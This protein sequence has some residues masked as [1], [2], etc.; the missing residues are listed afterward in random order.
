MK[1]LH[2]SSDSNIT[3]TDPVVDENRSTI[4]I[5]NIIMP[6]FYSSPEHQ[7]SSSN[8]STDALINEG[9]ERI[10]HSLQQ[11]IQEAQASLTK[12]PSQQQKRP[13]PQPHPLA[14][15]ADMKAPESIST[16]HHIH[17][18]R[19]SQSQE[20]ITVAMEQLEQSI[21]SMSLADTA[22][23]SGDEA[24]VSSHISSI[25]TTSLEHHHNKRPAV[26][27]ACSPKLPANNDDS[28]NNN[29]SKKIMRFI[30]SRLWRLFIAGTAAA[31]FVSVY[32]Y[33]ISH[34]RKKEEGTFLLKYDTMVSLTLFIISF[35]IKKIS[36]RGKK[37]TLL[38]TS[39]DK[40]LIRSMCRRPNNKAA[41]TG[42]LKWIHRMNVCINTFTII[43]GL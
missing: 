21:R 33:F 41:S 2:N 30:K 39:I 7:S 12:I 9:L 20:K 23:H 38:V 4:T 6:S 32:Y 36:T 28:N 19:Y 43:N 13:Q 37:R 5:N 10:G 18:L 40:F 11:L 16:S 14:A 34:Q 35:Y 31:L 24:E 42:V 22:T 1:L 15:H 8:S 3:D 25:V 26:S 29:S 27:S 17:R